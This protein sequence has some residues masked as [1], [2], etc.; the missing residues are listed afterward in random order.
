MYLKPSLHVKLDPLLNKELNSKTQF[1]I[2]LR[3]PNVNLAKDTQGR[4]HPYNL[5]HES[6]ISFPITLRFISFN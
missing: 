5:L 6:Q 3:F 2:L 1:R 4:Y